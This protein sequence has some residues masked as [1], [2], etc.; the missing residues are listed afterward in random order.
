MIARRIA[1]KVFRDIAPQ[2]IRHV[3]AVPRY[4]AG[5]RL[6]PTVSTELM[7]CSATCVFAKRQRCL[8]VFVKKYFV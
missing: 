4:F 5:L 8:S 7:D 6:E 3:Q 1:Q 2:V